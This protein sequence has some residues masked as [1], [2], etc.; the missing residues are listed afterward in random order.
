MSYPHTVAPAPN[1]SSPSAIGFVRADISV[2]HAD[3]HVA[4]MQRHAVGSGHRYLYTVRPSADAPDP[5]AYLLGIADA[6]AIDTI[7]TFSPPTTWTPTAPGPGARGVH[8]AGD[9][10]HPPA[11]CTTRAAARVGVAVEGVRDGGR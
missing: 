9:T 4:E 6:L 3:H 10:P 5:V 8:Q 2:T 7:I 1:A 11:S